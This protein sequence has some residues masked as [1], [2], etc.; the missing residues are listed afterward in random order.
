MD[1][2]YTRQEYEELSAVR[3]PAKLSYRNKSSS[4]YWPKRHGLVG[5]CY[6]CEIVRRYVPPLHTTC[7]TARHQFADHSHN[8]HVMAALMRSK[9][10]WPR[11]LKRLQPAQ[12]IAIFPPPNIPQDYRTSASQM[13]DRKLEASSCTL[14][15]NSHGSLHYSRGA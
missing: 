8:H 3:A 12:R 6:R 2:L 9:T 5:P 7:G 4:V 1:R 11:L 15:P 10:T 13:Q 14:R